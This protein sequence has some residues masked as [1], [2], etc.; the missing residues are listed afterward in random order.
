MSWPNRA[1]GYLEVKPSLLIAVVALVLGYG[2]CLGYARGLLVTAMIVLSLLLHELGHVLVASAY[3][4]RVKRIGF[5]VLGGY[6]VREF[7]ARRWVEAQSA[8]AGPLV[9]L[10]LFL[11]L[12]SAEGSVAHAVAYANL[13]LAIGN[14]IPLGRSDGRRLWKVISSWESAL[15]NPPAKAAIPA[16]TPVLEAAGIGQNISPK[17]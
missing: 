6:T 5:A 12:N 15:A 17:T 4:V 11:V 14:M 10:L 1:L 8:V 2:L 9:N 13:I 16:E 3:G 7:S